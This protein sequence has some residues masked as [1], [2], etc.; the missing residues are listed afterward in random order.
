MLAGQVQRPLFSLGRPAPYS[1]SENEQSRVPPASCWHCMHE[2]KGLAM[3]RRRP[4]LPLQAPQCCGMCGARRAC[5]GGPRPDWACKQG[6]AMS[7][8]SCA[9]RTSLGMCGCLVWPPL[10][11]EDLLPISLPVYPPCVQTDA[12]SGPASE[13]WG[14][15]GYLGG[16]G[17]LPLSKL[18][19]RWGS[20]CGV[21]DKCSTSSTP[22]LPHLL[23]WG[24]LP[25]LHHTTQWYN[26]PCTTRHSRCSSRR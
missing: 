4:P 14:A 22:N 3:P 20:E 1:H 17:V 21:A 18:P 2:D 6:T 23:L 24:T 12:E 15:L 11:L 13:K 5:G 9:T 7:V 26:T 10:C 8:C 16:V 25:A 19:A